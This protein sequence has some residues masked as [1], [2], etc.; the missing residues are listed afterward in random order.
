M[1]RSNAVYKETYNRF[2]DIMD[3]LGV[4]GRLPPEMEIASRLGTSRT[5]V[6]SVLERL[7]TKGLIEWEGRRKTIRRL[8]RKSDYFERAE[9][10]TPV[11]KVEIA[12]MEYVLGG[13]LAPG[14]ILRES[15]LA[16]AFGT[17][18]AAVHEFMIDFARY[19]LIEKKPN[20]HWVLRG[21]TRS[22]AI[23][24]FDVREMFEL[25]AL[26]RFAS[27]APGSPAH[28]A[29]LELKQEHI[30]LSADTER[31]YLRFPRLDDRF[32]RV[33]LGELGNRF[34]DDFHQIVRM[35]FHFHYRWNKV[36]EVERNLVAAQEHLAVIEAVERGDMNA[37]AEAFKAHLDSA[38][39]TL[40]ASVQWEE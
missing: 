25:R 19:G 17:S 18:A 4:E 27:A 20:R 12:F 13:D 3:E 35:I 24:L 11:E 38:R 29:L 37:A 34:A 15:E 14:S 26:E 23:E 28:L 21:F 16:R 31:R 9:T 33:F 1:S 40:L 10:Q 36:D 32:H 8:P 30:E 6:R 2:L 5:T 22:Y 39:R 7:D